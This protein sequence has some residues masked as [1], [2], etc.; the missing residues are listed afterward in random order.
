MKNLPVCFEYRLF[1]STVET[2]VLIFVFSC[3]ADASDLTNW[4]RGGRDSQTT[5]SQPYVPPV[6]TT[7]AAVPVATSYPQTTA[8]P[9]L[10]NAVTLPPGG[11]IVANDVAANSY[12]VNQ[13]VVLNNVPVVSTVPSVQPTV[14]Y[15]WSYSTIKDTTYD[16]VTVYDPI[17]GGYVTSYQERKTESVLPW[18]H[19]KQVIR[20]KPVTE[21]VKSNRPISNAV[22]N[23][24]SNLVPQENLPASAVPTYLPVT[25]IQPTATILPT[26]TLS[27]ITTSEIIIPV[28]GTVSSPPTQ[29]APAVYLN[30]RPS[31]SSVSPNI[32]DIPPTLPP[33]PSEN[34]QTTQS[35][36][37][38]Q[39]S[40]TGSAL[41]PVQTSENT[42]LPSVVSP[43]QYQAANPSASNSAAAPTVTPPQPQTSQPENEKSDNV[44]PTVNVPD[45]SIP[46]LHVSDLSP[47]TST[48]PAAIPSKNSTTKA[49]KKSPFN[50]YPIPK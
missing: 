49:L 17:T 9:V 27:P 46:Q 12:S 31:E 7:P 33:L 10:Q 19:R 29:T 35:L 32:A 5:V 2:I 1:F 40:L 8:A 16:P 36:P 14:E 11:V 30:P 48:P 22:N 42:P 47:T 39:T 28:G 23:V 20:Y 6:V 43:T 15:E 25:S 3:V 37:T 45:V 18:L 44:I 24:V 26:T 4:L 38:P 50:V 34:S 13:P 21:T 41:R